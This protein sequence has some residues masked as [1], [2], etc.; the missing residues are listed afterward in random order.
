MSLLFHYSDDAEVDEDSVR[1]AGDATDYL[2]RDHLA[3]EEC[4]ALKQLLQL[5]RPTR[6]L[7]VLVPQRISQE[8]KTA[9]DPLYE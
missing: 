9:D 1:A 2:V 8:H 3:H 4:D 7:R 5:K 6:Y